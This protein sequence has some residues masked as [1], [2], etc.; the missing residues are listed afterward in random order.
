[1]GNGFAVMKRRGPQRRTFSVAGVGHM[2]MLTSDE[3]ITA[4]GA[5]AI[6][7]GTLSEGRV[8]EELRHAEH[9]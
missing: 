4:V 2:R 5:S 3:E 9:S 6:A 1:M 7:R 8:E